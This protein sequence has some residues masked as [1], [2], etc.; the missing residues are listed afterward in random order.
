MIGRSGDRVI[1]LLLVAGLIAA[2]ARAADGPE[3][4]AQ[5]AAERWLALVDADEARESWKAAAEIFRKQVTVEQWEAAIQAVHSQTG[6][7]LSRKLKSAQ[8]TKNPPNAP[9]GDYVILQYDS[10]FEK[11]RS[12]TETLAPMK[13]PDGV[14]RVSGYFVK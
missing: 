6:K 10:A 7:N 5:A 3:K 4:A 1:V 9:E 13:D 8:S 11:A 12:A 2:G 14:W